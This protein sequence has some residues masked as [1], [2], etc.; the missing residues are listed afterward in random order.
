[1]K[2]PAGGQSRRPDCGRRHQLRRCD[3]GPAGRTVG[4]IGVGRRTDRRGLV[5]CALGRS[6]EGRNP[7][8][9]EG[10]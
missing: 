5:T 10:G 7:L 2:K 1:M 9:V 4:E 8:Q 6:Y 3:R